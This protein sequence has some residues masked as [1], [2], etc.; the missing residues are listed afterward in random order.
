MAYKPIDKDIFDGEAFDGQPLSSAM[1]RALANNADYCAEN[2]LK[3]HTLTY[4]PTATVATTVSSS[5]PT[6][7]SSITGFYSTIGTTSATDS[8]TIGLQF[9]TPAQD[10]LCLPPILWPLSSTANQLKVILNM[11]STNGIMDV[12]VFGRIRDQYIGFPIDAVTYIDSD[13]VIAFNDLASGADNYVRVGTSS[14]TYSTTCPVILTLDLEPAYKD[15]SLQV[16]GQDSSNQLELFIC[17]HSNIGT[18]DY[19]GKFADGGLRAG[20]LMLEEGTFTYD[21]LAISGGTRHNPSTFHRWLK[22]TQAHGGIGQVGQDQPYRHVVQ[23]R[24]GDLTTPNSTD[25]ARY[26][27]WPRLP[28]LPVWAD[29]AAIEVYNIAYATVQS[30]TIQEMYDAS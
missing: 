10:V 1:L 19:T 26:V 25:K 4:T 28:D 2:R 11:A 23:L 12:Y 18:L 13:G 16:P 22:F 9:S 5:P 6:D 15:L 14:P 17:F 27:I 29:D 7:T 3:R 20:G 30:I 21:S 24:P 8:N